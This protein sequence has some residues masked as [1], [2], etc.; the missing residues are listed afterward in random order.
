MQTERV[1]GRA[2]GW[3][4]YVNYLFFVVWLL[5]LTWWRRDG[6]VDRRPPAATFAL[7]AF[8]FVIVL[9]AAVIFAVGWRRLAGLALVILLL[10]A[11]RGVRTG[12][13]R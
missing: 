3:G 6:C 1:F 10:A 9:N 4:V 8:Y 7:Q 5:D 13:E 11:W 2:V 12:G